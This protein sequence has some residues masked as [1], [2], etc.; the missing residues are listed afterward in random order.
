MVVALP[1]VA[2]NE[3]E[4]TEVLANSDCSIALACQLDLASGGPRSKVPTRPMTTCRTG[5]K[6]CERRPVCLE[7]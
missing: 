3:A 4:V 5:S 6:G 2:A 1:C 7:Q